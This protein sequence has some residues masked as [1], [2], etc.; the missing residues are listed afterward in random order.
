MT[1]DYPKPPFASQRQPMPGT[2]A[3]MQPRPDHV[4]TGGD[5]GSAAPWPSHMHVKAPTF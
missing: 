2:T 4:I 1:P 3:A 5:S